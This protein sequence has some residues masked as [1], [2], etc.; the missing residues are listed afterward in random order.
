MSPEA[1]PHSEGISVGDAGPGL[2][3]EQR[4]TAVL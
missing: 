3:A 2:A 1:V 4:S